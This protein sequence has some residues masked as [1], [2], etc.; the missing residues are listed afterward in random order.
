MSVFQNHYI[1]F[2]TMNLVFS[3]K[4]DQIVIVVLYGASILLK[5]FQP[6]NVY[7]QNDL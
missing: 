4:I 6:Y 2:I 7:V 1:Y 5:H 3:S